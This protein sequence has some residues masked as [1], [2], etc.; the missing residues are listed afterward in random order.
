MKEFPSK[1][2]FLISFILAGMFYCSYSL[3]WEGK[4]KYAP[5]PAPALKSSKS[6]QEGL[7]STQFLEQVG[8]MIFDQIATPAE[9]LKM[10]SLSIQYA[11]ENED[12]KRLNLILNGKKVEVMLYDWQLAPI[13]KYADS[14]FTSCL[15]PSGQLSDKNLEKKVTQARGL[16]MNYHPAFENT[17]LGLRLFHAY[18][19]LLYNHSTQLPKV[20]ESYLL[21]KGEPS[22]NVDENKKGFASFI[23]FYKALNK[24]MNQ[25]PRSL[26]ISDFSRTLSFSVRDNVLELNGAPYFFFWRYKS[27]QPDYNPESVA[28][29]LREEI[30]RQKEMNPLFNERPWLV[31][32]ILKL[33]KE[34]KENYSFL[35]SEPASELVKLR[36]DEEKQ[37]FLERIDTSALFD[38]LVNM[39]ERMDAS[40]VSHMERYSQ[41]ISNR[42]DLLRSINPLVWDAALNTMRYA[43][44]FRYCKARFPEQWKNFMEKI[45]DVSP[46]PRAETP[47]VM[48]PSENTALEQLLKTP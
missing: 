16:I 41:E 10:E 13:A 14:P 39:K 32:S 8:G 19:L 15:S 25:T 29:S 31:S 26:A 2:Y 7:H 24:E 20:R 37:A 34:Y 44:F 45:K 11:P 27:D 30:N 1:K 43:A 21:G 48:Y 28:A 6:V 9:G 22:P 17:L 23:N 40:S 36:S 5:V 35:F 38:L 47:T 4:F 33:T 12:G 42:P 46:E 3:E 18:L